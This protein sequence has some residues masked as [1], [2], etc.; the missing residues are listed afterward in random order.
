MSFS[1]AAWSSVPV[2]SCPFDTLARKFQTTVKGLQSWS[3]KKIGH[4]NSQLELARKIL[5]QLEIAQDYWSLSNLETWLRNQLKIHSL[6][7]SS[8]QR[9]IAR[10]RSRI[11]WLSEGD[12]NA[13]LFHLHARHR[14][15]KI[16]ISKLRP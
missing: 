12:A 1:E 11:S 10:S 14:K 16:F 3:H 15:R 6:A 9:T 5:H 13:A 2:S 7:L 8:L 4:V